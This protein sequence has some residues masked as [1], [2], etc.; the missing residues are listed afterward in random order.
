MTL[1]VGV[2]LALQTQNI[3]IVMGSVLLGALL[4]EWWRI[5]QALEHLSDRLKARVASRLSSKS[6]THFSEGFITASLVFCV[7]PMT[8]LGAIQD[9]LRGDYS[10]LAIKSL[11][12]AFSA[13]AF[14][15]SLGIGVLFSVLTILVYQGGLSLM[16][17]LAERVLS[18]A[19]IQEMTAAGGVLILAIGFLLLDVKRI[20]V[21][22]LLPAL[23]V[24]PLIV[25]VLETLH[26]SY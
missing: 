5:D 9:G 6:L 21:A 19:M 18:A 3:L 24:A 12:D 4:G 1:V 11:L 26:V 10:L 2:Q 17:G 16:A 7:G 25:K 15:S 14:A 20:R 23:L 8:I 13:L 22:N